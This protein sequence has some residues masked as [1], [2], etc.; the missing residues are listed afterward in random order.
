MKEPTIGALRVWHVPQVPGPAFHIYVDT[1]REAQR[2]LQVL[3]NYDL[4]QLEHNIKP[5]Y[6]NANGLEEY[7]ANDGYDKP[8]WVEWYDDETGDDIDAWVDPESTTV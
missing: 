1:L 7:V 3:A 4:F 2:V 5:D 6:C 8:G